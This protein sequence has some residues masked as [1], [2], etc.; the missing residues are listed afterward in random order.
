[1]AAKRRMTK[2]IV[3][4]DAPMKINMDYMEHKKYTDGLDEN[5]LDI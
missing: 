1:M 5:E 2:I 4:V 3:P